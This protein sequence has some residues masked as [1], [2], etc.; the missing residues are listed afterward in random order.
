VRAV[1]PLIENKD[2][3]GY[4][5]TNELNE[6]INIAVQVAT[7]DKIKSVD[8]FASQGHMFDEA[9]GAVSVELA[10]KLG[11]TQKQFAE[12]MRTVNGGL[13]YASNGEAD[14][15]LG[16]VE[17]KEDI[18]ARMLDLKKSIG[19]AI[20]FFR[21]LREG[22]GGGFVKKAVPVWGKDGEVR[23]EERWVRAAAESGGLDWMGKGGFAE[24][25][26]PRG[27]GGRFAESAG[28]DGGGNEY[29]KRIDEWLSTENIE[30]AK[31][32]TRDEIFLMFGNAYEPIANIPAEYLKYLGSGVADNTVYSGKGYFIDHAVN[33]H[34]EVDIA[35]YAKIPEILKNPD[36]VKLD[37]R[38]PDRAS[39]VF[40]KKY[41]RFGTVITSIDENEMGKLVIHKSF[42]NPKK[43]PYPRLKS[44]RAS[45]PADAA[46]AISHS[47]EPEPGGKRISTLDDVSILSPET[48]E[49][50]STK[51]SL[52]WSGYP[53]QGRTKV[54]GMDISIE[55]KKGSVRSGTDKDGHEW[56]IKMNYDYG[57]IRGTV[58]KDKDHL[59]V[60]LGPNP[61]SET[62][63]VIHQNDPVTGKYDE[64]KVMLGFDSAAEAKKAYLSQYDRP[65]FYGSMDVMDIENFKEK[66][67]DEK[68]RGK[69]IEKSFGIAPGNRMVAA[70]GSIGAY[71]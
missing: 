56:A 21:G 34:P 55:N 39:L 8:D 48:P 42:F 64:D 36:D 37:D 51:K 30:K 28:G 59:D 5:I 53:L 7:N 20:E 52:T 68:S 43:S 3:K 62:V 19:R 54:H 41:D 40:I 13:K 11:G 47:G 61:E 10:K 38:N 22:K 50:S 67:F 69:R 25:E 58:G 12:F 63:Y 17:S 31:G 57:Y 35:E 15:F 33:H 27:N 26:H 18:L 29:T 45:S 23:L 66:V 32:K 49:K 46:S 6:A 71:A 16:G 1:T 44:I 65:D 70:G 14:I 2:L 9:P 4:S 60:Y 24:G